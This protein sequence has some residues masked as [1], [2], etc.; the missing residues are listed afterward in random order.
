[1]HRCNGGMEQ[2]RV[3][4]RDLGGLAF[5]QDAD[6]N[7]GYKAGGADTVIPFK[8]DMKSVTV[9]SKEIIKIGSSKTYNINGY[10]HLVIIQAS[11]GTAAGTEEI[12]NWIAYSDGKYGLEFLF[13]RGGNNAMNLTV[14]KDQV[15]VAATSLNVSIHDLCYM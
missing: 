14:K 12:N 5:A 2:A 6:G 11:T 8:Q 7:W 9:S 1:M 4:S 15:I 10:P 13:T 3:L